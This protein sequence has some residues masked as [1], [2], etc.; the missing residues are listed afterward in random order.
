MAFDVTSN[1]S[2]GDQSRADNDSCSSSNMC[3]HLIVGVLSLMTE[4]M[5]GECLWQLKREELGF[6][7][8]LYLKKSLE[9]DFG[10]VG[11]SLC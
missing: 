10:N 8:S 7:L 11:G 2:S 4:K 6:L 5:G 3:V 9:I 1:S